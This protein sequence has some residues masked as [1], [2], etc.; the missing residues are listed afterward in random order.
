MWLK[1]A[2]IRNLTKWFLTSPPT[3]L[4]TGQDADLID[5][6]VTLQ[7]P[8]RAKQ[9]LE[10]VL[11]KY[12]EESRNQIAHYGLLEEGTGSVGFGFRGRAQ[13]LPRAVGGGV[14]HQDVVEAGRLVGAQDVN[15]A[16]GDAAQVKIQEL[17]EDVASN[18]GIAEQTT[19]ALPRVRSFCLDQKGYSYFRVDFRDKER[20]PDAYAV[21]S[22]L[23]EFRL[24]HIV[25]NSVSDSHVAGE[26]SE[27]FML[28][29]SQFSGARLKHK[30]RVIDLV[31][32]VMVSRKTR[33]G[34]AERTAATARELLATLSRCAIVRAL[35]ASQTSWR[36]SNLCAPACSRCCRRV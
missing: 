13:G 22:R 11:Q 7:D 33:E 30:I 36:G 29:L 26:R 28:D 34:G 2:S 14:N 35:T 15:Q 5:L 8:T 20:N 31:N 12:A 16:A 17:E 23:V 4:Q 32:G 21:L 3:G 27:V 18:A 10:S 6:D 25:A 9:F 1:V 24:V 19:S